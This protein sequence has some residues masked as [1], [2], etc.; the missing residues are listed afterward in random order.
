MIEI[1]Y[2]V[3]LQ[4]H[5]SLTDDESRSSHSF[6]A[7]ITVLPVQF[8]VLTRWWW[9][10]VYTLFDLVL[11]PDFFFSFLKENRTWGKAPLATEYIKTKTQDNGYKG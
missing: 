3:F 10:Q 9:G 7:E 1:S 2:F 11:M 5:S 4:S 6:I 8:I